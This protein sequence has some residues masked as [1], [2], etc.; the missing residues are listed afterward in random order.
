MCGL[1]DNIVDKEPSPQ[2]DAL[3]MCK[4]LEPPA[5]PRSREA[6]ERHALWATLTRATVH[7]QAPIGPICLLGP[8]LRS[9]RTEEMLHNPGQLGACVKCRLPH[10]GTQY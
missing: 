6:V 1:G 4:V 3:A 9:T 7:L 8:H 5:L 10:R 2:H